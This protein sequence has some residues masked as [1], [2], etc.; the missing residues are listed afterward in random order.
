[1]KDQG[2]IAAYTPILCLLTFLF[3]MRVLAQALVAFF[4]IPSLPSMEEWVTPSSSPFSTSGL[5]PYPILFTL[6]VLIL[7]FQIKV[8]IDFSRG[9]GYFVSLRRQTARLLLWL[10][11]LYF[12]SMVLRYVITMA[13]YPER[14][15]LGH[16]IPILLHFVL[17]GFLF[18]LGHYHT[19][20]NTTAKR[21]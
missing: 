12:T 14:R 3:L 4:D 11:Y 19:R 10:S 7:I 21:A 16:T 17:A 6:Q 18:T 5:I 9:Y 20:R 1:M 15:W 2:S 13:L 8:C